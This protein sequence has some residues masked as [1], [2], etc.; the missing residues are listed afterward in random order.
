MPHAPYQP[1][2]LLNIPYQN[3]PFLSTA[4]EA[5]ASAA[6]ARTKDVN[7]LLE[8]MQT[9]A[10]PDDLVFLTGDFNEPSP[11]DWSDDVVIAG[12][13][14]I[15]CHWPTLSSI[16]ARTDLS[17]SFAAL[18]TNLFTQPGY[19][20]CT[21]T[22]DTDPADH[23]DRIDAVLVGT[24]HQHHHHHHSSPNTRLST[25]G[26]GS[27]TMVWQALSAKVVGETS[28]NA[29][30]VVTPWPSDHRAVLSEVR[31]GR[32]T[33]DA[34]RLQEEAQPIFPSPR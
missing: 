9:A 31:F 19:T 16:E 22:K 11:Y 4:Q 33:A 34:V 29:D 3:H 5:I 15:Q 2:Q 30:M 10:G 12:I 13:H 21:R 28:E 23:H 26:R 14:P 8:D 1:Y 27:G 7:L 17:D 20:W 24:A 18:R 6:G 25:T 32:M